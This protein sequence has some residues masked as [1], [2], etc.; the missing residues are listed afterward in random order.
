M[1]GSV[2]DSTT[3][4]DY[5][6]IPVNIKMILSTMKKGKPYMLGNEGVNNIVLV[7]YTMEYHDRAGT[8]DFLLQD[9]SGVINARIFKKT[10]ATFSKALINYEF[11]KN[12]YAFIIGALMNFDDVNYIII[13]R[14]ANITEY[15]QI[16]LHRT[17]IFWAF[18]V[19][20]GV[21]HESPN[22]SI[23]NDLGNKFSESEEVD[24]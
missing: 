18:L 8:I 9:T 17:Q 19:R 23:I 6:Y 14:M 10:G 2:I 4:K 11:K 3:R 13:S 7:A 21:I 20:N 16:F 24:E 5:G 22:E 1:I 12:E 15:S